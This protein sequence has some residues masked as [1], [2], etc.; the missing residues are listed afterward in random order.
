MNPQQGMMG[1]GGM[2]PGAMM[3]AGQGMQMPG[4][5]FGVSFFER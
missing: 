5:G 4:M 3:F 1:Q 2:V